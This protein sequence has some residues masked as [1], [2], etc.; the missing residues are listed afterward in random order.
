[1]PSYDPSA[2]RRAGRGNI[3]ISKRMSSEIVPSKVKEK[4]DGDMY[5]YMEKAIAL[6]LNDSPESM[7][8]ELVAID[9]DLHRRESGEKA[10]CVIQRERGRESKHK[11]RMHE[12]LYTAKEIEDG[13]EIELPRSSRDALQP[14]IQKGAKMKDLVNRPNIRIV[15]DE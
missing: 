11:W 5:R 6:Q 4:G 12:R 13:L 1:M 14:Q 10:L 3:F 7:E 9:Y 15:A 2:S 8:H